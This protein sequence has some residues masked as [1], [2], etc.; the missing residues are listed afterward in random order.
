MTSA[1][2]RLVEVRSVTGTVEWEIRQEKRDTL[3]LV[4]SPGTVLM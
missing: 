1:L 3:L 4:A 2:N